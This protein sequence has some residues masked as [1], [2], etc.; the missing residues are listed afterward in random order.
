MLSEYELERYAFPPILP[1]SELELDKLVDLGKETILYRISSGPKSPKKP[2]KKPV[3]I[4][5]GILCDKDPCE[6]NK[7][8]IAVGESHLLHFNFLSV[9]IAYD[10]PATR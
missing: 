2:G 5:N 4:E 3:F 10:V 8:K 1:S 7:P 6:V 9:N